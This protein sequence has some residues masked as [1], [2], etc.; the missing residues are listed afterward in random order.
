MFF[1]RNSSGISIHRVS[2]TWPWTDTENNN[3]PS[4]KSPIKWFKYLAVADLINYQLG[5]SF[6]RKRKLCL[7]EK[8]SSFRPKVW[9]TNEP[10]DGKCTYLLKIVAKFY[11]HLEHEC[12][13]ASWKAI[14]TLSDVHRGTSAVTRQ[15]DVFEAN[16]KLFQAY[17]LSENSRFS[18]CAFSI[19]FFTH[20]TNARIALRLARFAVCRSPPFGIHRRSLWINLCTSHYHQRSRYTITAVSLIFTARWAPL[21]KK[22]EVSRPNA[23]LVRLE[24]V[25]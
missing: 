9:N 16:T 23:A 25:R 7:R 12:K 18:L 15:N 8:F 17:Q 20:K 19:R 2:F 10:N 5:F 21:D 14:D 3:N 22:S 6:P 13:C 1:F 11:L 4:E 24:T